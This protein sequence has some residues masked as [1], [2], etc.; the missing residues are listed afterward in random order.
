MAEKVTFDPLVQ[1]IYI[2]SGELEL[3]AKV[4]LYSDAK[5]DWLNPATGFSKFEFPFRVVGGDPTVGTQSI[6]PYFFMLEDWHLQPY[7]ADAELTIIGNL[8]RDLGGPVAKP[9]SGE[10]TVLVD[11]ITTITLVEQG[12]VQISGEISGLTPE[13]AAQLM[14]L[15]DLSEIEASSVLS[16]ETTVTARPTLVQIEASDVLAKQSTLEYVSGEVEQ[17]ATLAE[18]EASDVLAKQATLEYVSGELESVPS[19]AEIEASTVLARQSTLEFISGEL[20]RTLGLVQENFLLDNT[21]YT[22]YNEQKLLTSGRIRLFHAGE[23]GSGTPYATY[24]I[25]AT[26]SNDELQTYKVEKQ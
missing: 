20:Q 14:S 9:T 15:P 18:I 5:E 16:K 19:L 7:E 25:T 24:V 2:H 6:S 21:V 11:R 22:T 13:Q 26:W 10:Y 17:L 23:V 1:R 4:D 8:F 12:D 3:N